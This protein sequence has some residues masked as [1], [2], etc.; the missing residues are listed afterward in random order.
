[1]G[2]TFIYQQFKMALKKMRIMRYITLLK[3]ILLSIFGL[4]KGMPMYDEVKF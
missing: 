4:A 3:M 2:L 1:M